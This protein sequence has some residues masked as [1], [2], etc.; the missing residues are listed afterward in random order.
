M[1]VIKREERGGGT[2]IRECKD[3]RDGDEDLFP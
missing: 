3:G 2:E 1:F